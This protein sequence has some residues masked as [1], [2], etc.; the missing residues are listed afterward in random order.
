MTAF[1]LTPPVP[2]QG[3]LLRC[4]RLFVTPRTVAR[5]DPLSMDFSRQEHWSGRPLP[6][7]EAPPDPGVAPGSPVLPADSLPST[8]ERSR[9][10]I[11]HSVVPDSTVTK[12][13]ALWSVGFS[14]QG[15]WSGWPFPPPGGASTETPH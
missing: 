2:F 14:R 13:M 5:Q 15:Y 1:T 3:W 9:V 11:S 4:S 6:S 12:T 7:S 10:C 8:G